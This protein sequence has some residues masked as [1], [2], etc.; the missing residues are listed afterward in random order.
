MGLEEIP[1]G[2]LKNEFI[3]S[4]KFLGGPTPL[5]SERSHRRYPPDSESIGCA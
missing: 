5:E 4:P 1:K 2:K 3:F